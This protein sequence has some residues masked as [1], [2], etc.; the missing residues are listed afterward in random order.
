MVIKGLTEKAGSV[1][2]KYKYPIVIILIGIGLLIIPQKQN[3]SEVVKT[4]KTI[5]N[6]T[7]DTDELTLI[8][9]SV[10]GAGKVKVMLSYATGEN[11]IF[12]I[13]ND[14]NFSGDSNATQSKT[15]VITDSQRA[16]NGLIKRIDPPTYLGAIVVCEGAESATVRLA[17]TQAVSKITGLSTDNICV[18]KM[19][20]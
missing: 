16:E 2:S 18:L 7:F 11:T 8:L 12:Q 9:Q 4:D 19:E 3:K 1:I 5:N 17:I 10:Q 15:V 6:Q 20:S 13:D 14:T